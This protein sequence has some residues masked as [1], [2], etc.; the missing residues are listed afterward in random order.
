[1]LPIYVGVL[2]CI[3]EAIGLLIPNLLKGFSYVVL[4]SFVPSH[5]GWKGKR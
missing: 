1:M 2:L 4:L 3:R 5:S